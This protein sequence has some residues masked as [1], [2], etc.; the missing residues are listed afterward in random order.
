MFPPDII[1]N[2]Y[3]LSDVLEERNVLLMKVVKNNK[4][5]VVGLI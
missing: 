5:R 4:G 2:G 3:L 1:H